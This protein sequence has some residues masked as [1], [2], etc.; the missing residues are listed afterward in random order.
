M[1]DQGAVVNYHD[2]YSPYLLDEITNNVDG[3]RKDQCLYLF[4]CT[5]C[6][7]EES[8]VIQREIY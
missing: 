6:G 7:F 1:D 4:R 2:N 3:V 5:D 8:Y